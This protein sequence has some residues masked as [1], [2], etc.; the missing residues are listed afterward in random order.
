MKKQV[1]GRKFKRDRNQRK[2]LFS[3]LISAMILKGK[4]TTTEEKAKAIRPGLEKLVTKAKKGEISKRLLRPYLKP[5][6]I[7]KMIYEIG[8]TFISR[9]GGYTRII[10]TGRRLS[11]NAQLAIIEWT[12]KIIKVEKPAITENT[13]KSTEAQSKSSVSSVDKSVHSVVARKASKRTSSKTRPHSAK[14]S[15]GKKETK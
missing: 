9:A 1:Y 2:A 4:I 11:D 13:E 6:E 14:A 10:K 5:F 3:G 7:D 15:R 8:P 12:D